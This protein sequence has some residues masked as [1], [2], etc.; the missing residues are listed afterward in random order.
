[1]TKNA[2]NGWIICAGARRS[3]STLYYNI[4]SKIVELSNSGLRTEYV[5]PE[6]FEQ[7]YE[8]Y[9]SYKGYKVF[10]THKLT[11]R[12]QEAVGSEGMVFHTYRDVRDVVV[13]RINKGWLKNLTKE[14]VRK[15]IDNYLT[16]Y[17]D[18]IEC[19]VFKNNFHSRQ[20]ENFY[21]NIY[22]EILFVLEKLDIKLEESN[23]REIAAQLQIQNLKKA[24]TN[25]LQVGK[26]TFDS[27]TLLHEDH[28]FSGATNQ[29]KKVLSKE[30][31]WWIEAGAAS[32]LY[33]NGYSFEW[34]KNP[35]AN[36][37]SFS[38]HADDYIAWCML[39]Q[40]MSGT[41]IEVGA[42][43]GVHLS[44]SLSLELI[45]WNTVC[46][47]PNPKFFK[48][49]KSNRPRSAN[50]NVA[51]VG[52]DEIERIDFYAEE[53]GVLSGCKIDEA[54]IKERYKKRGIDYES[55]EVISIDAMTLN[56]V[57]KNHSI[58]EVDIISIDV[59]GFE[60]EVLEGID[61]TK[62]RPKLFIIEANNDKQLLEIKKFFDGGKGYRLLLKN[63]Q[64]YFFCRT[65]IKMKRSI[66][67]I[68]MLPGQQY[69]P[70]GRECTIPAIEPKTKW[71]IKKPAWRRLLKM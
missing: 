37:V 18:W 70:S 9:N 66:S 44:N 6:D 47:E 52:N 11:E 64:N 5:K 27:T 55:P 26:N 38:Q 15:V 58:D 41:I 32:W 53:L 56:E 19:P 63:R 57:I 65:D 10:K 43:D 8:K 12:M 17:Y 7:V 36:F 59:E 48:L 22:D 3:G 60:L 16:E 40:P 31:V 1:M 20:Y 67:F 23:L 39:G 35:K 54:D 42:F 62:T 24:Q 25:N 30:I 34:P 51:V 45:G 2:I 33:L 28:V 50:V 49:L 4:V 61:F 14:S 69:H 71:F 68:K 13:S 29:F 46:I 21:D